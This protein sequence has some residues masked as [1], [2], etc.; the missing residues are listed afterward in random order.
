LDHVS[1][2]IYFW[3]FS[4][5]TFDSSGRDDFNRDYD[6]NN[7]AFTV[8]DK[9]QTHNEITEEGEEGDFIHNDEVNNQPDIQ[10]CHIF[11]CFHSFR[12]LIMSPLIGRVTFQ[13]SH[14][15]HRFY[16]FLV[17]AS[18]TK[19]MTMNSTIWQMHRNWN[20]VQPLE[21]HLTR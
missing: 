7:G 2:I 19:N 10:T 3:R 8:A 4:Q 12:I 21:M 5:L 6:F 18:T 15:L 16:V 14:N 1:S 9:S 11:I 20:D 17:I 13:N